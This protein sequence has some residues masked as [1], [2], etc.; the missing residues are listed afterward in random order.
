MLTRQDFA[1]I[2]YRLA[3]MDESI[4]LDVDPPFPD[5]NPE[6]YYFTSVVWANENGLITG[7]KNGKFGVGDNITREMIATILYRY[8][9][10]YLDLKIVAEDHLSEFMD[11]DVHSSWAH[12]ALIWATD[13]GIITGKDNNTRIDARGNATRA[14]VAAM[15]LRFVEQYE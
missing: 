4:K 15:I 1:V 11:G 12:D 2:L 10:E 8:L 3:G 14:E 7:Y 13:T 5:T 9:T 6:A